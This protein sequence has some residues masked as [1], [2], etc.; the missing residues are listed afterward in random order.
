MATWYINNDLPYLNEFPQ[1]PISFD[2]YPTSLW[3]VDDDLPYKFVF[4]EMFSINEAPS[5][6][7]LIDDDLPYKSSFSE[8]H[9][10]N[11]APMSLWRITDDLPWKVSFP[12]M[13]PPP[14]MEKPYV[15]HQCPAI[16]LSEYKQQIKFSETY[17]QTVILPTY[18]ATV[19]TEE[20]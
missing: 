19:I 9:S 15:R 10:I 1:R 3:K 16:V 7:W 2:G 12:P 13:P 20:W 18:K 5:A 11:D 14:K 4:A 17:V 8:I 6:M